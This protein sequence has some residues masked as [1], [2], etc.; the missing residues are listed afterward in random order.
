MRKPLFPC[1]H[2]VLPKTCEL[3]SSPEAQKLAFRVPKR[4]RPAL[5][6]NQLILVERR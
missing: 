3:E 6:Q 4:I 2:N 1:L 5:C